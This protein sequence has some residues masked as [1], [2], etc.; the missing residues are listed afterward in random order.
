MTI[1][2]GKVEGGGLAREDP[3]CN[4]TMIFDMNYATAGQQN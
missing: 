2:Y 3:P 1:Y 4:W